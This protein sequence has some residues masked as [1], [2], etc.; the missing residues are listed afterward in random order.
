MFDGGSTWGNA[1]SSPCPTQGSWLYTVIVYA[2]DENDVVVGV[3][4]RDIGYAP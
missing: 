4:K 1:Y 2:L 3:G